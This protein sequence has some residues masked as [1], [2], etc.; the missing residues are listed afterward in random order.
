MSVFVNESPKKSV[1]KPSGAL[2]TLNWTRL[3]REK[4]VGTVWETVDDEKLYKQLDLADLAVN[5]AAPAKGEN[6]DVGDV[7]ATLQRRL[8]R[9]TAI[10]VIDP[11]RAQ[12]CTILLSKLK[13][14]NKEIRH[15]VLSMDE[16][17]LLPRDMLDQ[18]KF[19]QNFSNG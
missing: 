11:R 10:T 18:V 14:T 13:L 6:V 9:D 15:A 17:G 8:N 4:I 2:K 5:F 7:G 12:N 1:P 16:R 19:C 3:S